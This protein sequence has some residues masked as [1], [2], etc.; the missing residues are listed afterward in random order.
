MSNAKPTTLTS[1][2]GSKTMSNSVHHILRATL[3]SILVWYTLTHLDNLIQFANDLSAASPHARAMVIILLSLLT[4]TTYIACIA[5]EY[6]SKV[7]T[8]MIKQARSTPK[9]LD[10]QN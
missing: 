6:L 10:I 8:E 7:V 5:I 1:S 2:K 4:F 3:L 9:G